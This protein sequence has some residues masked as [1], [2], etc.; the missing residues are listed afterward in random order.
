MSWLSIPSY[1][2]GSSLTPHG[3]LPPNPLAP[4]NEDLQMKNSRAHQFHCKLVKWYW[5]L[6][7]QFSIRIHIH[8]YTIDTDSSRDTEYHLQFKTC[9]VYWHAGNYDLSIYSKT[10]L[11]NIDTTNTVQSYIIYSVIP[12]LPIKSCNLKGIWTHLYK[13]FNSGFLLSFRQDMN[14]KYK[15]W[16]SKWFHCNQTA[17]VDL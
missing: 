13:L 2:S 6:I 15:N 12:S 11:Y 4:I 5:S 1:S 8:V 14:Y 16:A 3:S 7:I 9:T 10:F 17:S